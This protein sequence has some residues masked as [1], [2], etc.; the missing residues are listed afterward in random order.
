MSNHHADFDTCFKSA[1]GITI[2]EI[3]GANYVSVEC[4]FRAM[5]KYSGNTRK[6]AA[7]LIECLGTSGWKWKGYDGSLDKDS[8]YMKM[9]G[10]LASSIEGLAH[11][12]YRRE[13]LLEVAESRPY[14]QF[15]AGAHERTPQSCLENDGVIKHYQDQF[16]Q[17]NLP[18]C[19]S[20]H[21][22]CTVF[23]LSDRDIA[24]LSKKS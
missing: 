13:Q 11:S 9:A 2:A 20:R 18:P 22:R 15:R 21:C 17:E 5:E 7:S 12:L 19:G 4:L 1:F 24:R 6:Q 16:W 14:W 8:D 10:A 3:E 23:S